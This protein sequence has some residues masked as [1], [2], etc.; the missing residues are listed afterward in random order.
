MYFSPGLTSQP[1]VRK[2]IPRY[3][4]TADD[5]VKDLHLKGNL[6]RTA[7]GHA[8]EDYM[9]LEGFVTKFRVHISSSLRTK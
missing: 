6:G 5:V 7:R 3:R 8:S 9:A 2:S 4:W 1:R